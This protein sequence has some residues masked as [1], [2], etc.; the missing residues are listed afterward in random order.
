VIKARHWDV[1]EREQCFT[2]AETLAVS[3]G[4]S[5]R[6]DLAGIVLVV[7]HKLGTINDS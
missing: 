5:I 7:I 6:E 1:V 2:A 4:V 3:N